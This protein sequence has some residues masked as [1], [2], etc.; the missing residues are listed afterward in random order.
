MRIAFIVT[1]F[2]TLSGTFILDKI[3]GLLARGH[4]V[5]VFAE[6]AGDLD[7][8]HPDVRRHGLLE[9]TYCSH[10]PGNMA[11]RYAR[12]LALF[13]VHVWRH[14][15]AVLQSLNVFRYGELSASLVLLY[16]AIPLLGR[17][18]Y[19]IISC[20]FG[21]NGLKGAFFIEAGLIEGRLVTHFYGYDL[22][23]YPR[24]RGPRVYDR[25]FRVVD[26]CL[27]ISTFLADRAVALGC[28]VEKLVRLP[29]G[30]DLSK[31][32]YAE[33]RPTPGGEVRILTVGRLTEVKGFEY[34][35]RAVAKVARKHPRV[36]YQ[37]VGDGPLMGRLRRLAAEL[38]VADRVDF[39]G[40]CAEDR[41]LELYAKAH[42]FL[43][44]GV[45]ARDGAE[46]GQGAVLIEAQ[47]VGLPVVA[48]RVGGV[49]EAVVDGE[50]AFLVPQRD[51]D[52][53]VDKLLHLLD[54]PH[55]WPEMGLAGRHYV[56]QYFDI[57]R[58]NDTLVGMLERLRTGELDAADPP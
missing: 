26:L 29:I 37:I 23:V 16:G 30:K 14:P 53:I 24:R 25:L 19:D 3:T 56:E 49:C 11:V 15:R 41:V 46:E 36:R 32:A 38:G 44:A 10:M 31:F 2:P 7:R 6:R 39:L 54:H 4:Q 35:I 47:A 22:N 40:G 58:L 8:L 17:R 33:R 21:P 1:S 27:P 18:S 12:G 48:T 28:P 34:S 45:V 55:I 20:H 13:L 51:V 50:S 57:D 5:D 43:L 42:I 52:A 9:R